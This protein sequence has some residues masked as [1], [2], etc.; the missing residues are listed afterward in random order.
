[1]AVSCP[2]MAAYLVVKDNNR[3]SDRIPAW[4]N[5]SGRNGQ[6]TDSDLELE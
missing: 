4:R 3:N 6:G 1:M 2:C 5:L